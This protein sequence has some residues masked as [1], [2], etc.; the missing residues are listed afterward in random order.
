MSL[1]IPLQRNVELIRAGDRAARAWRWTNFF[2]EERRGGRERYALE[3]LPG[4]QVTLPQRGKEEWAS[5]HTRLAPNTGKAS[6]S[7]PELA[8]K[9]W[10]L[11]ELPQLWMGE[12]LEKY[13]F[14][15]LWHHCNLQDGIT[16]G[17]RSH[18]ILKECDDRI[19]DNAYLE[20]ACGIINE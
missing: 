5:W 1:H 13:L 9:I 16:Q 18:P 19:K 20:L 15:L 11:H 10:E 8:A 12:E 4:W 6:H 17:N 3:S 7:L 2:L 14:S